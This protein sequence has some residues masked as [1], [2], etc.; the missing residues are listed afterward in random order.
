MTCNANFFDVDGAWHKNELLGNA[1]TASGHAT[2]RGKGFISEGKVETM[3]KFG[4]IG[5]CGMRWYSV[6]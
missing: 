2:F 6:P 3:Q 1:S 5:A 4:V